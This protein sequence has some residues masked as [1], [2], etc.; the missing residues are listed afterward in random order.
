M[1][2]EGHKKKSQGGCQQMSK[3]KKEKYL[4]DMREELNRLMLN[5]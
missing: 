1:A 3:E 2:I 4:K 5:M